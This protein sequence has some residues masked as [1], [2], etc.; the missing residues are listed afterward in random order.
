MTPTAISG[1]QRGENFVIIVYL[2]TPF[3]S[4]GHVTKM[5]LVPELARSYRALGRIYVFLTINVISS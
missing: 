3:L 4:D 5:M 2:D 1:S